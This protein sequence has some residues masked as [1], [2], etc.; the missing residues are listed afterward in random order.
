[1]RG[2]EGVEMRLK[3][4]DHTELCRLGFVFGKVI[5]SF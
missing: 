5:A 3:E 1:M 4:S 2:G